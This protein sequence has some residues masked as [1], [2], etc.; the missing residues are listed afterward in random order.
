[1]P[2]RPGP[3]W[4]LAAV[5]LVA[6]VLLVA[7]LRRRELAQAYHLIA[8]VHP[9]PVA[10]AVVS[11]AL[12]I[13]CFA[14]LYRWLLAAGGARWGLRRTTGIVVAA[15][16]VAGT[17][18]GGAAFSAAW[19]FRQLR[20]RGVEQVLAAAV[21]VVAG[22]L[23]VLGLA[24]LL[25][26]ATVAAGPAE[27]RAVLLP[28]VG[29][30]NILGIALVAFGATRFAGFRAAV[31]RAWTDAGRR[32]RRILQGQEALARLVDQAHHLQPGLRPWLGPFAFALLN[33]VLDVACL[34]AGLWALGIRVP[35]HG[36]LF[37]Y[38]LTQIPGSL[39]LTP[40]SV[41]IIETSLSALLI[42][43]GLQPGS[44]I[45]ATL[46]YRAVSYSALQPIGWACWLIITFQG[47]ASRS[48]PRR[49]AG[50]GS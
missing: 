30:L 1:M 47:G 43:Y 29:V 2:A 32:S 44:A 34:A 18:P 4:W 14:A 23:S 16:A 10:V 40:G 28:G 26:A 7:L 45:A 25:V 20:R 3:L 33:W 13:V 31:R 37:A 5:A 27:L 11:E 19:I 50:R 48:G 9:L 8:G 42:L 49:S 6:A 21:L 22:G 24:A 39:R 17:L 15:N 36:L 38:V 41:G 46:L 12:S 35:W